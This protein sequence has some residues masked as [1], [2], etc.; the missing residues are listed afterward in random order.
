MI[1]TPMDAALKYA[2]DNYDA[3]LDQL[4]AYLKIPS[5]SAD[6]R[7][8]GDMT[9]CAE[10]LAGEF[11]RI[12]MTHVEV[13][14]TGGHPAVF[15]SYEADPSLPTVLSYGHYDVQP[16]DPLDEWKTPPFEPTVVDDILYCRG[17]SDDKGQSFMHVKAAESYLKTEGT[18]PINLKFIVE[19]EE[20]VGSKNLVRTI[21]DNKAKLAADIVLIS[22]T[23]L[24][25]K[26]VP[27]ITYALRGMA[28]VEVTLTG[29]DHDL[30]SGVFGGAVENPLN[31][32]AAMIARLHDEQ[33]RITI[34]HFYDD[35]LDLTGEE[36]AAFAAL[37]FDDAAFRKSVG[38]DVTKTETGYTP[39]EGATARP[40]LDINGIW[41]GYQGEGAKTVLPSKAGAKISCRLVP[42]QRSEDITEKLRQWFEDNTPPTMKL[43]FQDLHGGEPVLVDRAIPA[44]QA[45]G[46]AMSAVFGKE[47][48][49]AREGGSIPVVADFKKILGIDTVLMGFGLNTDALHSPNEHFGLDRFRMGIEA[50][51]RFYKLYAD[52]R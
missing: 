33:H 20:E 6:R 3:F 19:G 22:D 43:S 32:L 47:A 35:V 23:A 16:P 28:Y 50:A 21:A 49:F 31:A 29:P 14:E 52:R 7:H 39:L 51:I 9:T 17:S 48:S 8:A 12:G 46:E 37:P 13:L 24:F 45:A 40:T 11:R 26:G 41:G 42:N 38:V 30:H 4:F 25:A 2:S 36:R 18:L 27:S 5:V 15:A 34:P 1:R 44:M 10:W